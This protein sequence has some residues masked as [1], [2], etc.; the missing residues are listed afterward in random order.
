MR[1]A[2]KR[3]SFLLKKTIHIW[4]SAAYRSYL[5][6]RSATGDAEWEEARHPRD[7]SGQFASRNG[8]DHNDSY[9]EKNYP[10]YKG[11]GQKAVD[12]L[13]R[14][15]SGQIKGAF[16]RKEIGDIDIV[17]GKVID[18]EKHT[19]YGL[20]HIIDKHGEAVAKKLGEIVEKGKLYQTSSNGRIAIEKDDFTVAIRRSWNGNKKTWIVTGFE[21][22]KTENSPNPSAADDYTVATSPKPTSNI[23]HDTAEVKSIA[24]LWRMIKSA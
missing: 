10:E 20:A 12:F 21:K 11:Q 16:N 13:M 24:G 8:E 1:T 9:P 19:G 2:R 5:T 4:N 23:T 15:Q 14:K 18:S 3:R 22:E 6:T 7:D 17:W